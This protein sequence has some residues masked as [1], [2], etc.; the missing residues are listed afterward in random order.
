V[1]TVLAG[2][3]QVPGET[4]TPLRTVIGSRPPTG[5]P[6]TGGGDSLG[7]GAWGWLLALGSAGAGIAGMAALRRRFVSRD[8]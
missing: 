7:R 2:T 1:N 8:D 6:P 3:P 4:P 5:L